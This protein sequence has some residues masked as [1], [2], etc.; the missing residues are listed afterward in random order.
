MID[1]PI[2]RFYVGTYSGAIYRCRLPESPV[3]VAET[4][5]PSF[6]AMHPRQPFLYAVNEL[7]DGSVS[8]WEISADTGSLSLAGA[9]GSSGAFPCHVALD[10]TASFLVV[11][12]YE[13][14]T[15]AALDVLPG[16]GLVRTAAVRRH[17]GT[18]VS[19]PRQ[20]GPHAHGA[21]FSP[22]RQMIVVPDLG[23]DR[24]L[25]FHAGSALEPADPPSLALPAGSGP[26]HLAFHP[27]GHFAYVLAELDSSVA[28][29]DLEGM[30]VH[31]AASALPAGFRGASEAAEIAIDS[32]GRFLYCSNR[33]A[34][35]IAVFSIGVRGEL[36]AVQ[37]I[38]SGGRMPRHVAIDPSGGWL[39]AANQDSD[40]IAAFHRD[41]SSGE[42]SICGSPI[43]VPKPACI[44]FQSPDSVKPQAFSSALE[45][46]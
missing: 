22:V 16:G 20:N 5:A 8:A 15:V 14:G 17:S 41:S 18:G 13:D 28:L 21:F 12:N 25:L 26:R 32:S 24:L 40:S 31:V 11:C 30:R 46:P 27:A 38:S 9:V 29:V 43:T 39:L 3:L 2:A 37:H 42:L 44:A 34:D 10:P 6:L 23:L 7:M 36:E 33:G 35:S 4:P 19:Q 45:H 1:G